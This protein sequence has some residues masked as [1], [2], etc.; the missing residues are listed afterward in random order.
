MSQP[1]S[2]QAKQ[3]IQLTTFSPTF[4]IIPFL[5]TIVFQFIKYYHYKWGSNVLQIDESKKYSLK[6]IVEDRG[7]PIPTIYNWLREEKK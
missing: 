6:E 3:P 7:V 2:L 1:Q 5:S 4:A